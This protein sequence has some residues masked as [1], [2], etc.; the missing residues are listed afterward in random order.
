ML[1]TKNMSKLLFFPRGCEITEYSIPE[2]VKCV[3]NS[4]FASCNYLKRVTIPSTVIS[5]E[6]WAFAFCEGL[7]N[8]RVPSSVRWV[9]ETAFAS[10]NDSSISEE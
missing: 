10:F 8:V 7:S 2:G 4:A 6:S 3:G 1:F 5:I 9:G